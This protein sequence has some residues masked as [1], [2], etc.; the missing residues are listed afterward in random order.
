M[1]KINKFRIAE[2]G[3]RNED[4]HK[5]WIINLLWNS[6][7]PI[8]QSENQFIINSKSA[9]RGAKSFFSS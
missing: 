5:R 1:A 8:P 4:F 2:W 9:K 3:L 6:E 7:I